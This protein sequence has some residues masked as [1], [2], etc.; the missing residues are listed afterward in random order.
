MIY[1]IS[2]V[3]VCVCVCV[4]VR[5][6]VRVRVCVCVVLDIRIYQLVK[7]DIGISS[8]CVQPFLI[9]QKTCKFQLQ[10]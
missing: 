9:K 2:S 6:R 4:R 5:V 3:C 8:I 1:D 10:V 7:L